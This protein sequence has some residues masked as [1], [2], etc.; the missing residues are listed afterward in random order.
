[1]G[2]L[3]NKS[4]GPSGPPRLPEVPVSGGR[5]APA[6]IPPAVLAAA[7]NAIASLMTIAT[8]T[9]G[10]RF[11]NRRHDD[12]AFNDGVIFA[13]ADGP[14]KG[15]PFDEI[16]RSANLR[17]ATGSGRSEATFGNPKAQISTQSF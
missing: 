14:A 2:R 8:G 3:A 4:E 11:E 16:L 10:S 5:L 6:S 9:P 7:D 15:V 13:K 1:A 17:L 12:L